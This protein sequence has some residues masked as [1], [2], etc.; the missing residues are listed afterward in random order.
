MVPRTWLIV[1]FLVLL[2]VAP[3]F[4]RT[5]A[6][7]AS[8]ATLLNARLQETHV[9]NR[10]PYVAQT[11]VNYCLFAS[12]TMVFNYMGLNTSLDELLFYTGIGYSHSYSEEQ[13]LPQVAIW[14]RFDFLY[15]LFG[16][17]ATSWQPPNQNLSND[18]RWELYYARVKENISRDIPVITM[19][20]PF[21]LPSLRDQFKVNDFVWEKMF[22]PGHHVIVVVGYN[23][24]NQSI[25]YQDPNAGYYGNGSLGTYA[26]MPLSSFRLAHEKLKNYRIITYAQTG[27]PL[28]KQEAFDEAFSK[29]IDNLTGGSQVNGWY[30]GI[31]AS[32]AMELDFSPG[33]NQSQETSRMY[34][35]YCG[36][37]LNYTLDL[38]IHWL[39]CHI[40]PT[41]PNIYDMIVAGKQDPFEEI[42][43]VQNHT[44]QYLA[45]CMIHPSLCKN[46]S[47][48]LRNEAEQWHQLSTSYTIF[49]R[50]GMFLSNVRAAY[51]MSTMKALVKNIIHIEEALITQT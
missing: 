33:V 13:R 49:M 27:T 15:H 29:N 44:A 1:S 38:V 42:A 47:A 46:Q 22:P 9:I 31:N 32:E 19:V 51:V 16:V 41:H 50:K 40:D 2:S 6:S 18:V 3:G 30:Y 45:Q 24:A 37:G 5:G 25:C 28:S 26:W 8:P 4:S 11:E 10:V 21:S 23:E 39:C 17:T 43:A 48:L 36:T 14:G 12:V 34:K 7:S 20:D 35:A